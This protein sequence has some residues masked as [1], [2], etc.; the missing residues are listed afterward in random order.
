VVGPELDAAPARPF[1]AAGVN[2]LRVAKLRANFEQGRMG[3]SSWVTL[4]RPLMKS[5]R[6]RHSAP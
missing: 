2:G 4:S 6:M 5:S 3:H 1:R